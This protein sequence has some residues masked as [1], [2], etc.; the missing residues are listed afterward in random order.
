MQMSDGHDLDGRCDTK[1]D[2][3]SKLSEGQQLRERTT[4]SFG[5]RPCSQYQLLQLLQQDWSQA[6]LTQ[7]STM[8]RVG[9]IDA[10]FRCLPIR[11]WVQNGALRA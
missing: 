4:L 3:P 2:S 1:R 11:S 10:S 5:Y 8:H 9:D 7:M 6:D